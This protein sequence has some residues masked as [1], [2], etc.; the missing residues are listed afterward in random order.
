[1]TFKLITDV[2]AEQVTLEQAR[3]HCNIT[4][5][6]SPPAH[7]DDALLQDIIIPAAR[8]WAEEFTGLALAPKTYELV[9]DA[10]PEGDDI[11]LPIGP[12]TQID[13]I[14]YVDEDGATQ[15]L[16]SGAYTTDLG[17]EPAHV[18]P[19]YGTS[20][21]AT[22]AQRG[23]V[24]VV[25]VTG[26]STTAAIPKAIRQALLLLV[27]VEDLSYDDAA[28]VMGVPIG[29]VMSRLYRARERVRAWLGGAPAAAGAGVLKVVK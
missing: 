19:V 22:R 21:P 12:V 20:W 15:T 2:T 11:E 26:H 10:F 5:E 17:S 28:K 14:T 23:A 29:T 7:D 25:Y 6:G 1:M 24:T 13:S 3:K 4:P 27:G 18:W 16:S 8:E 9:L